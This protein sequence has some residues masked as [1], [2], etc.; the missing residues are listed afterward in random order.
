MT[1]LLGHML[2]IAAEEEGQRQADL[3]MSHYLEENPGAELCAI[4]SDH[5]YSNSLISSLVFQK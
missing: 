2:K 4:Y 5:S 1:I 3:L